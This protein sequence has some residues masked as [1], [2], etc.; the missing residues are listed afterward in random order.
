MCWMRRVTSQSK[1]NKEMVYL[2]QLEETY[3]MNELKTMIQHHATFTDSSVAHR[4]IQHW[5]EY[6]W[7][8]VKVIPKDYKR[9]FDA[10]EKVKRSGSKPT[11]SGHGCFRGEYEGCFPCRWKLTNQIRC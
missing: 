9:M 5:D 3:E 1:V 4:V 6:V 10:I 2:E 7:K 11:R 8:F